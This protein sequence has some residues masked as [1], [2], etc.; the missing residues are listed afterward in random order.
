MKMENQEL[1][2]LALLIEGHIGLERQGP[3]SSEMT[4][5]A[6]GFINDQSA[7]KHVA[8]LGCG[9]GGQTMVLARHISGEIVGV[10]LFQDF[11]DAFN[12]NS[13]K[14]SFQ[15]RVTGI[16]GSM[17]NLIF[18]KESFDLI[19]SE[20]AIDNIGF[21]T[22]MTHWQSFLKQGGHIAVTCPSWL[23]AEHPAEVDKF[24][25]DAGSGLD[26][27]EHNIAVMQKCGYSFVAAFGIPEECWKDNYFT[28]REAAEK[29]LLEKYGNNKILEDYIKG[30]RREV[31]L[32]E[33]YKRH[34]GYAFYIGRKG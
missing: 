3:G 20:G 32:F 9:S 12:A 23:T 34:Y 27:V 25:A 6:L 24:W 15:N 5:K 30:N 10:D 13:E 31:E 8:D 16:V 19:W 26:N 14:L 2:M 22:G 1:T 7:I 4:L 28:P 29:V 18:E 11:I 33:K 21:E 17:E